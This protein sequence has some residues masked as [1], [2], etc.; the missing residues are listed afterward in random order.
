MQIFLTFDDQNE[1]KIN[2]GKS[3]NVINNIHHKNKRKILISKKI[4]I[5]KIKNKS[6]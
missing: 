1:I 6:Q 5:K 3:G 4:L 2:F